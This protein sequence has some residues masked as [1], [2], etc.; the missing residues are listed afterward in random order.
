MG[1]AHDLCS[2]LGSPVAQSRGDAVDYGAGQGLKVELALSDDWH[3]EL[4]L[5]LCSQQFKNKIIKEKGREASIHQ[6]HGFL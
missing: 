4:S 3:K 6:I 1:Y 2:V 5:T